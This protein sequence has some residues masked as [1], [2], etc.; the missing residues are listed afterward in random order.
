MKVK[1]YL[2]DNDKV[3]LHIFSVDSDRVTA[4]WH[5]GMLLYLQHCLRWPPEH[6]PDLPPP[7][8]RHPRKHLQP[9]QPDPG[10]GQLHHSLQQPP[11][12]WPGLASCH[13]WEQPLKWGHRS[14][15]KEGDHSYHQKKENYCH[16]LGI[17]YFHWW[18]H[19]KCGAILNSDP[20]SC[21]Y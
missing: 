10:C 8:P 16:F 20:N 11:P 17:G 13:S 18:F 5:N 9:L 19:C 6:P 12:Y 14:G 4:Q 7:G 21:Q 2:V 1:L 15:H 3:I